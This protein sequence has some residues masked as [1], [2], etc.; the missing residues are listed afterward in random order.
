MMAAKQRVI[1]PYRVK[2]IGVGGDVWE[3]VE[4]IDVERNTWE[5]LRPRYTTLSRQAAYGKCLRLNKRWNE[6][7]ILDD[8]YDEMIKRFSEN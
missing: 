8:N 6:E 5:E 4:M 3:V 1:G 7:C 2:N